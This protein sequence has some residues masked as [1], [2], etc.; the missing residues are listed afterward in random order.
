MAIRRLALALAI[1]LAAWTYQRYISNTY[2]VCSNDRGIYTVDESM[3]NVACIS[4]HN[5]R[6]AAVGEL[7]DVLDQSFNVLPA[8][9]AHPWVASFFRILLSQ[10]V[11]YIPNNTIIVPGLADAHAHVLENGYMKQLPLTGATSV[12]DVVHLVKHYIDDHPEIRDNPSRWVEGMGWDQT[13]WPGQAFPTASDLD[14]DPLLKGR[15]ILLSRVDGHARW[16]SSAI[17]E[18]MGELPDHVEGGEILRYSDGRPTGLFV[19]NAMGLIPAPTWTNEQM[20]GF[21]HTTMKEALSVGLTSIHDAASQPHHIEFLRFQAE[22]GTLPIRLYL[23]GY[24]ER[25]EYWGNKIPRLINYG[26][27]SRLN[28][29][30]VKLFSDGALGSWGA[31]LLQPYSDKPGTR[32]LMLATVEH[33]SRLVHRFH[34][35]GWQVNVHCIGDRANRVILDIFEEVLEGEGG[36]AKVN[37]TEWRPRIEHAQIFSP[38]DLERIGR[39]GVIASV[40]PTHATSDMWYAERRLGPERIK[41]AYAYRTLLDSSPNK[42]IALG[43]DFPVESVNP[44]LGF[45]AAVSRLSVDGKSPHGPNGWYPQQRLTRAQALKGMTLD[46]AYASFAEDD[47]GSLVPGKKA[48]FVVLN[49]DIM[50][51]PVQEIPLTTVLTTFV[52]GAIMYGNL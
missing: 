4:I 45:Y 23:M 24:S 49:R 9:F 2:V 48:D 7:D 25:D 40:Q 43:S 12:Q 30:S 1:P 51:I 36:K 15:P 50:K 35:D 27:H 28:L 41:G 19:D 13:K 6:I 46:A 37:I 5:T 32:G 11:K 39:L 14:Q 20:L 17:L 3:P 44:L 18:M 31:A 47:L 38:T 21:Y 34:K 29:R 52:D 26:K 10:R 33:L 22:K 42:M 16:V 8:F